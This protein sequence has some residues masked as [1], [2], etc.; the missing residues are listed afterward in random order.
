[1]NASEFKRLR[2]LAGLTQEQAARMCCVTHR[3]VLRWEHGESRIREL[4]GQAIHARMVDRL[5]GRTQGE[6]EA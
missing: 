1:M 2:R 4:Q 3:T 6:K 5:F